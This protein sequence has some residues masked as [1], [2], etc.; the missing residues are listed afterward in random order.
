MTTI[1]NKYFVK[2]GTD[3]YQDITTKFVGVTLLKIDSFNKKGKSK[4]IY[5]ASR[6]SSNKEDIYVPDVVVFEQP[7]IDFT[8]IVRDFGNVGIDVEAVHESFIEYMTTHKVTIKS[9]YVGQESEFVCLSDYKP[10]NEVLHRT[11]GCNY[12]LGTLT[13]HRVDANRSVT[14]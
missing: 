7:D 13:M 6:V 11:A 10:T 1:P 3:A 12:I 4:N 5:T 14:P 8:F 9:L 2:T